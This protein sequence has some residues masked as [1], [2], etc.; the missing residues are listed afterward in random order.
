M[1]GVR[2]LPGDRGGDV[3]RPLR[4]RRRVAPQGR[5]RARAA[6]AARSQGLR[7]AADG[8]HPRRGAHAHEGVGEHAAQEHRG[9]ARARRVHPGD[10]EPGGGAPDHPVAHPAPAVHAAQL[11]RGR[12]AARG[13]ARTGRDRLRPGRARDDRRR[14][15]WLDPRRGVAA[16]PGDRGRGRTPRRGNR[17]RGVRFHAVRP[18]CRGAR[19]DRRGGHGGRARLAQPA[20]RRRSRASP[21][22]R[23]SPASRRATR[24]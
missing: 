15:G 8:V 23:G 10:H 11:R 9:A 14:G 5:R 21:G 4:D 22:R 16:G 6:R 2:E 12:R 17:R 7:R 3:P 20:P 13:P 1:R 24:S 19:G 18:A